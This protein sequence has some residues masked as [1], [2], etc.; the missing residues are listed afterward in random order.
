MLGL[1]FQAFAEM[2]ELRVLALS[3]GSDCGV[4]SLAG[5]QFRHEVPSDA[6]ELV[7]FF[8]RDSGRFGFGYF[9]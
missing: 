1:L 2:G 6:V 3:F 4:F 5:F 7:Q 8:F 9:G